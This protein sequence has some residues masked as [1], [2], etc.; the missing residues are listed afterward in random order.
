L[1]G[2][3]RERASFGQENGPDIE[4]IVS[5]TELYAT[6]ETLEGYSVVYDDSLGLFCYSRLVNG[7]FEST[8]VPAT[9]APPDGVLLHGRETDEVRTQKIREREK[10]M[11]RR[12]RRT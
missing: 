3:F 9:S 1:V 2:V 8:A 12:I 10:Q 6:Y 5:G 4:L 7:R 11:D